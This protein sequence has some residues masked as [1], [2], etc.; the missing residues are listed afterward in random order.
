M[1]KNYIN[2][3]KKTLHWLKMKCSRHFGPLQCLLFAFCVEFL[4]EGPSSKSFLILTSKSKV[5]VIYSKCYEVGG[6][7]THTQGF[8]KNRFSCYKCIVH[9]YSLLVFTPLTHFCQFWF[10]KHDYVWNYRILLGTTPPPPE[11]K[12][13]SSPYK[14]DFTVTSVIINIL[15]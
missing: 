11:K 4:R 5:V 7:D 10:Y 8:F 13:W 1:K 9:V 2:Y 12:F 15:T 6:F 14:N 3:E